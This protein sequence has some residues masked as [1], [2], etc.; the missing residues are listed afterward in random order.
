[1]N[2]QPFSCVLS[3]QG[4]DKETRQEHSHDNVPAETSAGSI[5]GGV[6]AVAVVVAVTII[7][8][9][10]AVLVANHH[11]AKLSIHQD[12]SRLESS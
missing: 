4:G 9:V 8:I 6:V 7:V 11:R 5:I 12:V 1:M 10:I 3:Y 2:T